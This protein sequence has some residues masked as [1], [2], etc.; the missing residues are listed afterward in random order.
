[1]STYCN[2][3]TQVSERTA[4]DVVP[5]L[6]RGHR[7]NGRTIYDRQ[8]KRELVRR[9][10]Q[11]GISVAGTALAHGVN[12]NLLRRWIMLETTPRR[13]RGA[14]AKLLEVASSI[15]PAASVVQ[16]W[17]V[18]IVVG[19]TAVRVRNGVHAETLHA[20]ISCLAART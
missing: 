13:R 18:E 2:R 14:G 15:E 11:P 19:A 20:V 12:A 6:V 9:C 16:D 3:W 4:I 10:L 1:M 17:V 5:N 8:A 7:R